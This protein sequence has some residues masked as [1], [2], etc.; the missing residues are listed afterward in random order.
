MHWQ[1][2]TNLYITICNVLTDFY[3]FRAMHFLMSIFF[4]IAKPSN[5]SLADVQKG[6]AKQT[7]ESIFIARRVVGWSF[8]GLSS[9]GLSQFLSLECAKKV[10]EKRQGEDEASK[11]PQISLPGWLQSSLEGWDVVPCAFP[12]RRATA[13][14]ASSFAGS[15]RRSNFEGS[16][17]GSTKASFRPRTVEHS[18]SI[19]ISYVEYFQMLSSRNDPNQHDSNQSINPVQWIKEPTPHGTLYGLQLDAICLF[20]QSKF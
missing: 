19:N 5:N 2:W 12:T 20:V 8:F 9:H 6:N 1:K 16:F 7:P 17:L 11:A 18:R 14:C 3:R 15:S 13:R 10:K 4:F